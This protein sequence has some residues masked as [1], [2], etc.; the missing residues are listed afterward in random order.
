MAIDLVP[1][2]PLVKTKYN[3][4]L[5]NPYLVSRQRLRYKFDRAIKHKVTLVIAPAG[6]G[7]TT[8]VLE[9]LENSVLPTAWL[10]IDK[11]DNNPMVFWNYVCAALDAIQPG[12][13]RDTNYIFSSQTF[14][15]S[16]LQINIIIDHLAQMQSDFIMVLDDMHLITEPSILK[17]LSFLI[18][19]LPPRMHLIIVG[20]NEPAMELCNLGIKSQLLKI[21]EK[22]LRFQEEE[23]CGFY[24]V[25][26]FKLSDNDV[27]T[28][29]HFTE[30]WAAALVAIGMSLEENTKNNNVIKN[31]KRSRDGIDEYLHK[32]VLGSWALEKRLFAIRTSI[33]DT[34]DV[35]LCFEITGNCNTEQIL[36]EICEKNGFLIALDAEKTQYKYHH[37]FRDFLY[38][39]LCKS[40]PEGLLDLHAKAARWYEKQGLEEK[41]IK[42][43]LKASIY[44]EALD[45]IQKRLPELAAKNDY[46]EAISWLER[47]PEVYKECNIEVAIFFAS[48][49]A[50]L[51]RYEDSHYW[52]RRTEQLARDVHAYDPELS[53]QVAV[54]LRFI[55]VNLMVRKGNL[56]GLLSLLTDI[57]TYNVTFKVTG[58]YDF[59][60]G[61]TYFY[62]CP[63]GK[64][65]YLY[66]N[67][68]E[69][70]SN[71]TK[72]FRE[73]ITDNPGY[74]P[75]AAGEYLYEN[76]QME[77]ALPY[78]LEALT[79]AQLANCPGALVPV[80]VNLARIKRARG[81]ISG[82]FDVLT[83]CEAKLQ[84]INKAHWSYVIQAFKT[85]L[86]LENSCEDM[87]DQWIDASKLSIYSEITSTR[88]FD[89]I[90]Y[91]RTLIAKNQYDDAEIL[92]TRLLAF[93]D[94]ESRL[95]SK[96]EI[97]NL[98]AILSYKKGVISK[99]KEYIENSLIIGMEEGYMRNFIDE[100]EQIIDV[101]K[102]GIIHLK[103]KKDS[104]GKL[105]A[106]A[107]K[108]LDQTQ[109]NIRTLATKDK[110]IAATRT[111]KLLTVQELNILK[112]LFAA[113]TNQE[114][115]QEMNIGLRT[116]KTHIGNIYS[117]LGVKNRAQ[118]IKLV[119]D[120]GLLD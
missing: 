53:Q 118:C 41:A 26:G 95:H 76:N 22:D 102:Q 65:A 112:L 47:V 19:Y 18:D 42:H 103:R 86:Y 94:H 40:D 100:F 32:E 17:G 116:V 104:S 82:A 84:N 70:Y 109:A 13:I 23:I 9:W 107:K 4:P 10:S 27:R 93:A 15:N 37:L 61:D 48:Y 7:K 14:L 96:V 117:K 101:L 16:H 5:V 6:Y 90:V 87:V 58:Y 38:K 35:G 114:I 89:F 106:Y 54:A 91:A 111:N 44:S 2:A 119:R 43:F 29:E 120:A 45:L 56:N 98:F 57:E 55:N 33:L 97:L 79:E 28:I 73:I 80:M 3:P 50:G 92:L 52:I 115:S 49:Y 85:R 24:K 108:L 83:E 78:L 71:M 46:H 20:R 74:A 113:Y 30:G 64:M 99:A 110:E 72:K 63:I 25:R 66:G 60:T 21:S 105:I 59:N 81:D 77:E 1:T 69:A 12:I 67:N 36:A 88:E 8:A 34:L 31:I 11:E 62:R 39:L 51:N 75:L 68:P